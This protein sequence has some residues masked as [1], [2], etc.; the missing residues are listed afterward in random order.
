MGPV[1]TEHFVTS[2]R[3]DIS[4]YQVDVLLCNG[5][6]GLAAIGNS[7]KKR[8]LFKDIRRFGWQTPGQAT[9][10]PYGPA[11]RKT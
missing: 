9:V 5:I 6:R 8:Y 7:L 10:R 1:I 3:T 4:L 11:V 2:K